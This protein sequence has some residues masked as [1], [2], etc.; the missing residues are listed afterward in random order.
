[1]VTIACCRLSTVIFQDQPFKA[2]YKSVC[3]YV[4]IYLYTCVCVYINTYILSS[5]IPNSRN[6]NSNNHNNNNKGFYYFTIL[7][8][9]S[10]M[11]V[12]TVHNSRDVKRRRRGKRAKTDQT[13]QF[14]LMLSSVTVFFMMK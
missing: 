10:Y 13:C 1:M 14:S 4:N 9:S 12:C 6:N 3:T 5:C 2:L 11:A 7:F 8:L